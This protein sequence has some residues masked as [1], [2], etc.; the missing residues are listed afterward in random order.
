MAL[1]DPREFPAETVSPDFTVADVLAWARTKPAGER[2]DYCSNG[3]CATAQ[4]LLDRGE[5]LAGVRDACWRDTSDKLHRLPAGL[6]AATI[7]DFNWTFGALV[8]RLEAL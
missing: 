3:E 1:Y 2:Y 5:P 6:N 8:K 7:G 4:F